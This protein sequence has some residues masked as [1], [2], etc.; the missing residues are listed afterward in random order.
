MNLQFFLYYVLIGIVM[1]GLDALLLKIRK[2]LLPTSYLLSGLVAGIL[3]GLIMQSIYS[4]L[5]FGWLLTPII[6]VCGSLVMFL[7]VRFDL[8]EKSAFQLFGTLF[9]GLAT[10][11]LAWLFMLVISR[12]I[13]DPAY[14]IHGLRAAPLDLVIFGFLLHFGYAFT[15]R[16][17]RGLSG[18][19][20]SP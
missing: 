5:G 18:K 15:G 3:F 16:I 7:A 2:E 1:Y 12:S 10:G 20:S 9:L 14:T 17:V 8:Y 11:L 4:F 13:L 19:R 6:S